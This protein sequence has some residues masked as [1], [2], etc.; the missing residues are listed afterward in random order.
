[1]PTP[2]VVS[3]LISFVHFT[4]YATQ[5]G[6][7]PGIGYWII[8]TLVTLVADIYIGISRNRYFFFSCP[9]CA[10]IPKHTHTH[11]H[12]RIQ[13]YTHSVVHGE[14]N[15]IYLYAYERAV[16]LSH[17]TPSDKLYRHYIFSTGIQCVLYMVFFYLSYM[18][19]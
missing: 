17:V 4:F 19:I 11:T 16:S 18:E 3:F 9:M 5:D 12:I 1:M 10:L 15:T 6:V 2:Y 7:R 13:Y 14:R 8:D